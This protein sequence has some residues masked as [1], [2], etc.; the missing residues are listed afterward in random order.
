[1]SIITLGKK[2]TPLD[3]SQLHEKSERVLG[4]RISLGDELWGCEC[5]AL[6]YHFAAAACP[7]E[8]WSPEE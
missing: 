1:M 4:K 7:P 2:G 5:K 6:G 3:Q 8:S